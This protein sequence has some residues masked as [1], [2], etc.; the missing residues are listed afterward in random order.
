MSARLLRRWS[1]FAGPVAGAALAIGVGA[2]VVYLFFLSWH[3]S[4]DDY[5]FQGVD[6]SAAQGPIDWP[7]VRAGGA[8]FA[9]LR[10]TYGATGRDARFEENWRGVYEAGMQRG[11]YLTYSICQLAADQANIFNTVVPHDDAALPPAVLIDFDDDCPAR[12]ERQVVIG[13]V[14]RLMA[15]IENHSGKP[16]LLK[17][18]RRFD[19][20]YQLSAAI[21]RPVWAIGNFFPPDYPARRWRMWQA[22]DR[23]RI[24]G[25]DQPVH[26]SVVVK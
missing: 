8:D 26:W 10:A 7:V 2:L 14:A 21:P 25:I 24:D 5:R 18:S 6:V 22:N 1:R 13:E 15:M 11:A 9:Y 17:V 4:T 16:A 3:P 19:A 20:W 23:R 12:P